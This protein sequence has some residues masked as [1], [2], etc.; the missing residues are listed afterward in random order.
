MFR[1][2]LAAT[3]NEIDHTEHIL[4]ALYTWHTIHIKHSH[5]FQSVVYL[6]H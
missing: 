6:N 2:I 1:L 4:N 5:T 3:I